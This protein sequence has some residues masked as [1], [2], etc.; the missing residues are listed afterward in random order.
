M[1]RNLIRAGLDVVGFDLSQEALHGLAEAGGRVAGSIAEAVDG[2]DTVITMVPTALAW[3]T[4][5]STT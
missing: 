1:S 3:M 5:R 2:A 4:R